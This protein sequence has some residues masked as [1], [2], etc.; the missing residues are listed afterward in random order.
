M[1]QIS[2]N[3]I[4]PST[5]KLIDQV[6]SGEEI[7]ITKDRNPIAKI[8]SILRKEQKSGFGCAKDDITYM[9]TD[10]DKTPEGFE[11]YVP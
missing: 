8:S 2:V 6:L 3:N 4:E 5:K 1:I 11:E 9:A 7:I 10:F